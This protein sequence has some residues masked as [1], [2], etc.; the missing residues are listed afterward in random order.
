MVS[1]YYYLR[2]GELEGLVALFLSGSAQKHYL[3]ELQQS[4]MASVATGRCYQN[5]INTTNTVQILGILKNSAGM[6]LTL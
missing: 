5:N 2:E 3:S 4:S 1:C 6:G